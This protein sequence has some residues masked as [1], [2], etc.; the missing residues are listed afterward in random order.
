MANTIPHDRSSEA[1]IE[2]GKEL[3]DP[4]APLAAEH[5]PL[6]EKLEKLQNEMKVLSFK[7]EGL[8]NQIESFK[9]EF[10]QFIGSD[11]I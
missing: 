3:T 11:E 9:F 8:Q 2:G 1:V 4:D 6:E 5:I 7:T 10:H